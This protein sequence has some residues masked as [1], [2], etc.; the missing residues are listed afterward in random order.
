MPKKTNAETLL[1][2]QR[3]RNLAISRRK[4]EM[5]MNELVKAINK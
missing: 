2:A 5:G 1:E 3:Q 4:I